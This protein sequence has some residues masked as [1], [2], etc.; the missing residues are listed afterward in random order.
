[1]VRLGGSIHTVKKTNESIDTIA[2]LQWHTHQQDLV[3]WSHL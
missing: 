3:G 1:M 2:S